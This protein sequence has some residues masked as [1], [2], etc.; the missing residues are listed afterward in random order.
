MS[1]DVFAMGTYDELGLE[2]PPG[3]GAQTLTRSDCSNC[4]V[5]PLKE[6]L[7]G[8]EGQ[9]TGYPTSWRQRLATWSRDGYFR[10]AAVPLPNSPC[11]ALPKWTGSLGKGSEN[12]IA[13]SD[14]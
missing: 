14:P 9:L 3:V 7:A 11:P 1:V 4:G 12:G 13:F 8:F 5:R 6:S 2:M 10:S